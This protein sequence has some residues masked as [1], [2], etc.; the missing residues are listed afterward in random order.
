MQ[1]NNV[2]IVDTFAEGF[3]S[4][5]A[6]V[7]ITAKDAYWAKQAALCATGFATST[8]HCPCEAGIDKE[9]PATETPDG[10]PGIIVMFV[11]GK[12]KMPEVLLDRVGQC[13]LTCP[14]TAVFDAF[15]QDLVDDKTGEAPTG[16]NLA[17][18]GDGFQVK[19]EES[20]PFVTH[21]IPVMGGEFV[22]QS[23]F[24]FGKGVAG[25]NLILQ[26]ESLDACA[27]VAKAAVEAAST[28]N[29]VIMP[30]PGG[31]CASGSKVGSKYEFLNASTNDA[32][33]PTLKGK[34]GKGKDEDGNP[35]EIPV[36]SQVFDG[37]NAVL[38][39]IFD[40][41]SGDAVKEAM[42]AAVQAAVQVPGLVAITAGNYE[43]K[44]GK[45]KHDFY[46]KD[47]V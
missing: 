46:L 12:E 11:A 24:K 45:G 10:R 22:V 25:G 35:I 14:S 47:L 39:I 3:S 38:E 28:V 31:V 4:Y 44:L 19:D 13:I 27:D 18:F 7:L 26:A 33:C 21:K 43:G 15:P 20:F 40:G 30:F 6:R 42:K 36:N 8:I 16:K 32:M 5:F 29:G 41:M 1:L 34:V 9:V 37:V 17:F 2:E 23:T